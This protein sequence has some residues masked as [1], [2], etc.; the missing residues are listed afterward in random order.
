[1]EVFQ[2]LRD[3]IVSGDLKPGEALK[4]AHIARQ[5]NLSQVPVRE[6]LLQLE[7]LGLV[8]RVP[9]R[10]TTVS[11]LS[12][13]E[14]LELL[15]VRMHLEELAFRLAARQLT[16][17]TFKELRNCLNSM[18]SKIAQNDYFGVAQE[19]LNFHRIVWGNCGNR[20]LQNLLE[21]LSTSKVMAFVS[22]R[23]SAAKDSL[24]GA[25]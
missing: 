22:L 16:D 1:M 5:F 25:T 12:R 20:L 18:E 3:A 7:H 15:Q 24:K 11:K 13:V 21:R 9:D 4:E 8:V 10:G 14:M 23:R 19:D 6:A 2:T 17:N